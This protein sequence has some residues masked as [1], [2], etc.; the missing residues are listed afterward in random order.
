VGGAAAM[1]ELLVLELLV[2]LRL[3]ETVRA[4]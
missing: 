1:L 2:L 4:S 3:R